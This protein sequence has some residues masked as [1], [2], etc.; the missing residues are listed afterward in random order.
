MGDTTPVTHADVAAALAPLSGDIA[1]LSSV[2]ADIITTLEK[3]PPTGAGGT[4][5]GRWQW[6][7]L[8]GDARADLWAELRDW[9]GWFNDRYGAAGERVAIPPCWPQHPL[10]VEELTAL[11]VAWQAATS[12]D[13]PTD[14]LIAW[15]DRWLWPCL[16]R[17]TGRDPRPGGF[18]DCTF[19]V[20]NLKHTVHVPAV[21]A[22]LFAQVVAADV[23]AHRAP[24]PTPGPH[25][26][27]ES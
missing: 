13:V 5:P 17:I 7:T 14:A 4:G 3:H 22:D 1:T 27:E 10:V 23:A 9:I 11:M 19:T 21:D 16:D 24:D 26:Q 18:K 12:A 8:T 15:H 25:A 6:R 20:H 2:V